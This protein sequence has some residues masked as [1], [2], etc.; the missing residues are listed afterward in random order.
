MSTQP[1]PPLRLGTS[2]YS[3]WHFT[4]EKTPI[5]TVLDAAHQLGLYGV[6]ILHRQLASED[7]S[8]LQGLKRHAFHLGLDIYN[9]SIHQDFVW[10]NEDERRQH[11]KH[12]LQCIDLAHS[13]GIGSIRVNSG[14]WRKSGSFDDLIQ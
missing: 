9:L 5:E 12:T 3:Y 8:Y 4:P 6:E 11:I 13:M 10:E 1:T 14:G 7:N 2:T